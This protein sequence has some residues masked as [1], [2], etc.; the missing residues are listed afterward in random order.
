MSCNSLFELYPNF[1][2]G[3][4]DLRIV[5][6]SN[7]IERSAKSVKLQNS[8]FAYAFTGAG[9]DNNSSSADFGSPDRDFCGFT[10]LLDDLLF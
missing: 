8:L 10:S 2:L 6:L 7:T 9:I 1:L 5:K 3:F 4:S